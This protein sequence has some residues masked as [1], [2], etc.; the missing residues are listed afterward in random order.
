MTIQKL[1]PL[2]ANQIAAGEV[3]ERPSSVVKELLENSID[4]GSNRIQIDLERGGVR[5]IRITDN[6]H[7]IPRNELNLALARHATSKILEAKDLEAISTLGFRGEALASISSV[8]KLTLSSKPESQ[9]IGWSAYTEGQQ[10]EVKLLP[11]SLPFGSIVEVKDLFFNTPARQKFLKAERTEYIHVED[12][13]KKIALANAN[14]AITLKHNGKVT[15]RIPAANSSEQ[16][17]QRVGAIVGRPFIQKAL[18]LDTQLEDIK[19]SGWL[20]PVD[21]HQSSSLSQYFFVNGRPVRDR[22]IN[23]A[24]RQAYQDWLPTGRS[25]A[26]VLFLELPADKLDINVHPTKHEVRFIEGRRVHD[27]IIK[28]INTRLEDFAAADSF[29]VIAQP[30]AQSQA[31]PENHASIHDAIYSSYAESTEVNSAN[32]MHGSYRP[33][34]N[35]SLKISEKNSY[36]QPKQDKSSQLW[37]G[38]YYL[39]PQES[40]VKLLDLKSFVID[41]ITSVLKQEW[42][43]KSVKNKPILIPIRIQLRKRLP[44]EET[45]DSCIGF[46]FELSQLGPNQLVIRKVPSCIEHC[47]YSSW[48]QSAFDSI[49]TIENLPAA[50]IQCLS[51]AW[52]PE[53]KTHWSD[54]LQ[55]KSNILEWQKSQYYY[56]ISPQTMGNFLTT[57]SKK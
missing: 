29:D 52:Q 46:G 50:L 9:D 19:L 40:K 12:V 28:A 21:Y 7:G 14:V 17:K 10:M 30:I 8:S 36:Y 55:Q 31:E 22:T 57:L 42:Q 51:D 35:S 43:D 6:G 2:I 44:I 37:F 47:D 34:N 20:G 4:A 38:Q 15:K 18:V 27:Y 33:E 3:V 49:D 39:L 25:P 16:I 32:E 23:H 13:V 11:H 1:S 45:I 54:Y 53:S 24:V 26:F 41:L 48:L 56:E 5:L